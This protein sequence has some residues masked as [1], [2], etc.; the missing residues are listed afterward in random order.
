LG[1]TELFLEK[2]EQHQAWWYNPKI[3]AFRRMRQED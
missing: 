3:P 2:T 1:L